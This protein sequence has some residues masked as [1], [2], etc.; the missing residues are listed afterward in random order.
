MNLAWK[1]ARHLQRL[2]RAGSG[3]NRIPAASEDAYCRGEHIRVI[4]Y[5]QNDL[6]LTHQIQVPVPGNH[7]LFAR[8]S[9]FR[10]WVTGH[11]AAVHPATPGEVLGKA[12]S[13]VCFTTMAGGWGM[14]SHVH[15]RR[16]VDGMAILHYSAERWWSTS[17]RFNEGTKQPV[18]GQHLRL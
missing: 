4:V 12:V 18:V 6:T 7:M 11:L 8:T 13:V 1:C 3:D 17:G 10:L 14:Q 2:Q 16:P 15:R 9:T 5:D